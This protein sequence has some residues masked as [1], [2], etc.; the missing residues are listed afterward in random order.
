M[1]ELIQEMNRLRQRMRELE[2][3]ELRWKK[4]E[5]TLL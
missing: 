2:D 4:A 5:E 3:A 1:E